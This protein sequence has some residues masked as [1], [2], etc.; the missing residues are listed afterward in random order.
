MYNDMLKNIISSALREDIG[1]GDITS[2]LCIDS[3]M[4]AEAIFLA[5]NTGII[6]GIE[7]VKEV[8]RQVDEN[9]LVDF[10][11]KNGQRVNKGDIIGQVK[12]TARSLLAGERVAL[13]FL[14]HLSGIATK[15]AGLKDMANDSSVKIV[16]TRKTTPNLRVLEKEAVRHGG[17]VNHRFSLDDGI[18]IKDNHIKGAGGIGKAILLA[19]KSAP[20]T[21]K[22]EVEVS[23]LAG[24]KEAL[25]YEADVILL[26]NMDLEMMAEAVKLIDGKALVEASGNMADKDLQAIAKIGVNIISIGGLTN[27]VESMDISMKFK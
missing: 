11:V 20:H 4:M 9:V 27:S 26:D 23:D 1:Y 12:G 5:K 13:N 8:F 14:Q 2:N 16:D 19:Q 25:E 18:L 22:I 3:N 10:Q 7:V 6:S 24:V 21:L 15:T 17:G